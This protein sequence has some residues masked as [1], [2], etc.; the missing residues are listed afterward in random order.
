[1]FH[2]YSSYLV[3]C[4]QVQETVEGESV[5]AVAMVAMVVNLIS[6]WCNVP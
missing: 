2:K 4:F 6:I 3:N 5:V 1:M